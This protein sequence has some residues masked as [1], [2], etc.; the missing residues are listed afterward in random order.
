MIGG[1]A[2]GMSA[3]SRAKRTNP[4]LGVIAL[5]RTRYV[6]YSAC[7]I[8]YF[9]AG[10]VSKAEDLIAIPP[11][12]FRTERGIDV[13]IRHEAVGIDPAKNRVRV[14]DRER[15]H[16][17][18]YDKLVVAVG[19]TGAVAV[20][21]KMQASVR[22]IYAAGDCVEVKHL[23]SGRPAHIPLGPTANK[24]GRAAGENAA[25]GFP[26]FKGVVGT[27]VTKVFDLEVA[28]T[29]LTTAEAETA[30]FKPV[31]VLVTHHGAAGYWPTNKPIPL[32]LIADRATRRLLGAQRVGEMGVAKRIDIFATALQAKMTVGEVTR[33]DLSYAPPYAPVWDP[34][35]AAASVLSK[36]WRSS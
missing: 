22:N 12:Q 17:L 21:R 36:Q 31:G 35:L 26:V 32:R 25:G 2:A 4:K 9:I 34:V 15:K 23:V 13:R 24:Q 11:H 18:E 7:G 28:R 14:A 6:S 29:G 19:A 30:G 16:E 10:L 27:A 3:A 33:L 8:P 1:D 20:D 5:E